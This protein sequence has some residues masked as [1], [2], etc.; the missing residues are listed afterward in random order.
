MNRFVELKPD[1]RENQV[2]RDALLAQPA[3]FFQT[4]CDGRMPGL[5]EKIHLVER[6]IQACAAPQVFVNDL[7]RVQV[8]R[9]PPFVHLNI[10]RHDGE[11]GKNW[12]DFQQIKNELVGP[13]FE[14]VELFPAESRLVD[15]DNEYH[16]WVNVEPGYRFP[17]GYSKRLVLDEPLVYRGRPGEL[18]SESAGEALPVDNGAAV[19][20]K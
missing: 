14:G 18:A 2:Y 16:L 17:V 20:R 8:R 5:M 13:E 10:G 1:V 11:P 4:Y 15:T 6:M 12:H 3:E 7:Y 19:A 9:N